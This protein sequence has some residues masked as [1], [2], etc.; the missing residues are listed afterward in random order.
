MCVEGQEV[1]SREQ[2]LNGRNNGD[3]IEN[4]VF[5]KVKGDV[6]IYTSGAL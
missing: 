4:E 3:E 6:L 5:R 2:C 1:L